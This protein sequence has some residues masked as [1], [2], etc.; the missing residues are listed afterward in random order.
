MADERRRGAAAADRTPLDP[1]SPHGRG[2]AE[3]PDRGTERRLWFGLLAAPAAWTIAELVGY[4]VIGRAC[5]PL[6]LP[7]GF[8]PVIGAAEL[9][10]GQ[11]LVVLGLQA[12]AAAVAVAAILMAYGVFRRWTGRVPITRAEGWNRVEF[13][14][15]GGVIV[16]SA[17]LLN[18]IYFGVMPLIVE[19]C[20]RT[21]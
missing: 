18:I 14:A 7:R 21:T 16:S 1:G 17:L 19:P 5:R 3:R 20:M 6:A 10:T 4:G 9:Q 8:E 15:I 11:W 13:M 12:A 2:V